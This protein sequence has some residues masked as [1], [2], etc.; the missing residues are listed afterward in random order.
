MGEVKAYSVY[1]T[2]EYVILTDDLERT[3]RDYEFP[4]FP[5]LMNDEAVEYITGTSEWTEIEIHTTKETD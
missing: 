3:K 4:T 1:L 5:D 2:F